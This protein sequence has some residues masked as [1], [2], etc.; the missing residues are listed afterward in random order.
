MLLLGLQ[1]S[2]VQTCHRGIIHLCQ[3]VLRDITTQTGITMA[4]RGIAHTSIRAQIG[5]ATHVASGIQV[6]VILSYISIVI[7]I[8]VGV[9][10]PRYETTLKEGVDQGKLGVSGGT[11]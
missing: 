9:G 10:H 7:T 4:Q 1:D 2:L 3:G 11:G 5:I 6:E 8:H